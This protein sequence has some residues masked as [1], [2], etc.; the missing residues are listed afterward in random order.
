MGI[1][2]LSNDLTVDRK[3]LRWFFTI[4]PAFYRDIL[5]SKQETLTYN[6]SD[7]FSPFAVYFVLRPE[8]LS[9]LLENYDWLMTKSKVGIYLMLGYSL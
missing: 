9:D 1:A 2:K 3:P 5:V 8:N 6:R 4:L 7:D